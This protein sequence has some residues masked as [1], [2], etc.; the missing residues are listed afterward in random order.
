[1]TL[2]EIK[3]M[4]APGQKWHALRTEQP[5]VVVGNLGNTTLEGRHRDEIR[6]VKRTRARDIIFTT[7]DGKDYYT[8]W[9]KAKEVIEA[10]P[11]FL[12]FTLLERITVTLTLQ[13]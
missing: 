12:K 1:M 10:K 6:T 11:G 4:F 5:L 7:P 2:S 13:P 8:P 9:P 3:S